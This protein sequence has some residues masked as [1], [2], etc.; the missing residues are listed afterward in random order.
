MEPGGRILDD[1][2][3]SVLYCLHTNLD[4]LFAERLRHFVKIDVAWGCSVLIYEH[5]AGDQGASSPAA[6]DLGS[7]RVRGGAGIPKVGLKRT[8]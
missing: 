8:G 4:Y 1:L 3:R 5:E 7:L 6:I 2:F